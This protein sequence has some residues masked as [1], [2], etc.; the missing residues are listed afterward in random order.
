MGRNT[1]VAPYP[2]CRIPGSGKA[3]AQNGPPTGLSID[4]S[5]PKPFQKTESQMKKTSNPVCSKAALSAL[6]LSA[7]IT[8][9]AAAESGERVVWQTVDKPVT[10]WVSRTI[11][12]HIEIW[13]PTNI[14]VNEYHTNFQPRFIT[15]VVEVPK[16][17]WVGI[18]VTNTQ[19]V[20][21]YRTNEV[22]AYK[23]NWLD[24]SLTNFQ[25]VDLTRTNWVTAFQTNHRILN[26]TNWQTVVEFR[27]NNVNQ[28]IKQVVEIDG[29]SRPANASV[30]SHEPTTRAETQPAG[31]AVPP[32]ARLAVNAE[33]L[34]AGDSPGEIDVRL[35]AQ[36][37]QATGESFEITEWLVEREDAPVLFAMKEKEFKRSLSPGTY[38]VEM[39]ARY[40][41][42]GREF[43][44]RAR[45]QL[46][47]SNIRV[48]SNPE[49]VSRT[50]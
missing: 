18:T 4:R 23:T 3:F 29:T 40:V 31:A 47:S 24:R 48:L 27:T 11:T 33:I 13:M 9:A 22:T 6:A 37:T 32:A 25:I 7:S 36:K 49:L 26:I 35:T 43:I 8:L 44:S 20:N 39:R 19:T 50:Q 30:T 41:P 34:G 10:K 15:N 17:N 46:T 21:L 14:F 2:H 12:N 28:Q 1:F 42:S 38:V 16:T 45:V 5:V